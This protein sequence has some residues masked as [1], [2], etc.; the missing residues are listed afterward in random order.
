MNPTVETEHCRLYLADCREILPQFQS[1]EIQ[2]VVTDPPYGINLRDNSQGGR[3][4]RKRSAWE[5]SIVGDETAEVGFAALKW[6]EE[7]RLPTITFAS[8]KLPWPG[9]WSSLLVWDKGPA[10]GGGGDVRR[11]WKQSWEM[12]QVARAGILNGQRDSSVLKFWANPSL[13]EFHP[14]AKPIALMTYLVQKI[15]KVGQTV[16]DPFM[17]SGTTLA[18]A[19]KTGRRAVGCEVDER[20]FDI[21]VKRIQECEGKGSLFETMKTEPVDMFAEAV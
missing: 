9:E 13:S 8:P 15:T 19:V 5:Y 21:A 6:C 14:A 16:F 7:Q 10:V 1:G 20:Y 4:G 12:I 11:C 17:G 2:A 3:Y 18:A